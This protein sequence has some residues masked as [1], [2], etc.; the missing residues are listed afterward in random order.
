MTGPVPEQETAV[1][2]LTLDRADGTRFSVT[3]RRAPDAAAPL[4]LVV[5][6]M[7]MRAGYYERLAA[8]LVDA[9]WTAAVMEQR[10]HEETGGRLPG[11]RY[12]F[13]YADL[14]DDIAAAIDTLAEQ[15]PAAPAYLLG[16][17]L[18]GQVGSVYAAGHPDR[19]AG[20]ILV[21]AGSVHW[22][23]WSRR[24]LMLSQGFGLTARAVG[25]FPGARIGF[26]GREARGVMRD[27]ARFARTGRLRFG[28]AD[29]GE[30]LRRLQLPV[31][32]VSFRGD[33]LAPRRSVDA[34][35]AM[36]PGVT[37]DRRHLDAD[38]VDHFRWA[39]TP[40]VV[41]PLLRQWLS[42]QPASEA[43]QQ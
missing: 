16:H 32:A 5:P 33:R 11:W 36:M 10:G 7:G 40:D 9:G 13:G 35:L 12:D 31:L 38:Q 27:W 37:V 26:A 24:F 18:G 19:L 6:A 41:V 29:H 4:V 25:H 3:L 21:A 30:A 14:V 8:A 22:R 28:G 42:E 20:L 2:R 34:L 17:S 23:V 1:E 15:A 43:G 39:R